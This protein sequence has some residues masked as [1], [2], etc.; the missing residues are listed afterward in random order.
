VTNHPRRQHRLGV[1]GK[2]YRLRAP[3]IHQPKNLGSEI[4]GLLDRPGEDAVEGEVSKTLGI[5]HLLDEPEQVA[6]P[7]K[8]IADVQALFD[9]DTGTGVGVTVGVMRLYLV[10]DAAMDNLR[11]AIGT[12]LLGAILGTVALQNRTDINSS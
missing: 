3:T 1:A 9:I 2:L 11:G 6:T 10:D 12:K 7:A 4:V 5:L 8:G